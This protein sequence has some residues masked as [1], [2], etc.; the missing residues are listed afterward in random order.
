MD[1]A[2]KRDILF[3][4]CP[5]AHDWVFT[6]G[7]NCGCEND[8]CGCSIPVHECSLCGDCDYGINED[9]NEVRRICEW[10]R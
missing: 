10:L 3:L 7:A 1:A 4:Q 8:T 5:Q 6:G 9:A 2:P